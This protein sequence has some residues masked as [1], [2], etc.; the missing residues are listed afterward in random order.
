VIGDWLESRGTRDC[1]V[2]T[3]KVIGSLTRDRIITSAEASL[4]RLKVGAVD[5]FFAHNWSEGV[6][7]EETLEALNLLVE[8]GKARQIGCSNFDA[9]QVECANGGSYT[10]LGT[11]QPNYNL[12]TRDIEDDLLP[13]CVA[14]RIGVIPYSPLGAGFQ[15]RKDSP[16][17]AGGRFDVIPGHQ[18]VYFSD[19][20]FR[21]VEAL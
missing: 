13:L 2:L 5:L 8:Q 14:R 11:I 19:E 10:P 18:D 7:L 9:S 3:T 6:E 20:N 17:P 15:Y 21:K 16:I 12:V 4:R 1:V